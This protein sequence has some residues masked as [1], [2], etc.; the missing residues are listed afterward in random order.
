MT[1]NNAVSVMAGGFITIS[2]ILA[3]TMGQVNLSQMSWLWPVAFVG[4]NLFQMG[5]TGFCPAKMVFK[6]LGMKESD[7]NSCCS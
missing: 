2:L 5:F 4:L 7:S 1:I 3:H 6:A